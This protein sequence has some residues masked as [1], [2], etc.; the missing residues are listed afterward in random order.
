MYSNNLINYLYYKHLIDHY[1]CIIFH[2]NA[3]KYKI[4]NFY[5]VKSDQ[6]CEHSI[7]DDINVKLS[8]SYSK[9]IVCTYWHDYVFIYV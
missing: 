1:L 9:S 3:F 6:G 7:N 8:I 5:F 4:I 2:I